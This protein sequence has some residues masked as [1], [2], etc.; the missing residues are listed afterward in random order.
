M[1]QIKNK[2]MDR[3]FTLVE[4]LVSVFIFSIVILIAVSIFGISSNVQISTKNIRTV[5]QDGRF[6]LEQ[7]SRDVRMSKSIKFCKTVSDDLCTADEGNYI[8]VINYNG[9]EKKYGIIPELNTLGVKLAISSQWSLIIPSDF[10]VE[11][12]QTQTIFKGSLTNLE[13]PYVAI[14]FKI[15]NIGKNIK[16]SEEVTQ[17]LQT[18]IVPRK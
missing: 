8:N 1:K 4:I 14:K 11:P 15:T 9:E 18:T 3:G 7:I 16:K 10:F 17:T 5:S 6:A 2:T 13:Q 12:D